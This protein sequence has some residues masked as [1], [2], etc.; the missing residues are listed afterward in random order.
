MMA[1][2]LYG[3]SSVG[4]SQPYHRGSFRAAWVHRAFR[5]RN[6]C[7]KAA[8]D[9]CARKPR[10]AITANSITIC[11]PIVPAKVRSDA[12]ESAIVDLLNERGPLGRVQTEKALRIGRM[13]ALR[14]LKKLAEGGMVAVEGRGR[15]TKYGAAPYPRLCDTSMPPLPNVTL[16][17]G[18]APT[19]PSRAW[20]NYMGI[21]AGDLIRCL[22]ELR[23][24]PRFGS[25][26]G[27]FTLL[28]SRCCLMR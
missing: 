2:G 15:G 26:S 6:P 27:R 20:R 28:D 10:F 17:L 12:Q 16:M 1:A 8:Y 13:S 11:L 21:L 7:F 18:S 9:G 19:R 25:G 14:P 3:W 24:C 23:A 22:A 5:G 4:A